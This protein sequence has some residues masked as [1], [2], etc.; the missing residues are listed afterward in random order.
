MTSHI[1]FSKFSI[2]ESPFDIK[3]S[4]EEHGWICKVNKIYSAPILEPENDKKNQISFFEVTYRN[5]KGA[6]SF[7]ERLLHNIEEEIDKLDKYGAQIIS[8]F[9]E[10]GSPIV[11]EKW[12]IRL[13]SIDDIKIW[14]NSIEGQW[15][16]W[17]E[18]EPTLTLIEPVSPPLLKHNSPISVRTPEPSMLS[19]IMPTSEEENTITQQE[20][21]DFIRQNFI[22]IEAAE[23]KK[24]ET[25]L[26]G[27]LTKTELDSLRRGETKCDYYDTFNEKPKI[28]TF[29]NGKIIELN[30]KY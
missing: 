15:H 8:E 2:N 22:I 30:R 5:T 27:L 10:Y 12:V 26:S 6:V 14:E 25:L 16:I 11:Y 29:P 9:D 17:S 7:Q 3:R 1:L 19:L 24:C 18:H 4:L 13:S 21:D 20:I 23:T 28:I